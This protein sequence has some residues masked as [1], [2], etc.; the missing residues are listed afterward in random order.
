MGKNIKILAFVILALVAFGG[1][2]ALGKYQGKN[3][4]QFSTE[5][6][7]EDLQ[8][9]IDKLSETNKSQKADTNEP[10][11]NSSEGIQAIIQSSKDK[12][13]RE[14]QERCQQ[15]LSE[16]NACL[17]EYNSKLAEY[18]SCLSESSDPN[19]WR[20]GRGSLCFKP[21]NHCFKPVCAY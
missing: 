6:Q 20:Y 4:S 7:L 18:N 13:A 12:A 15:E 19:S 1:V 3:N 17:S 10:D 16:Y 11:I 14:E 9:S 8:Q 2:Y 21:S 5:Q